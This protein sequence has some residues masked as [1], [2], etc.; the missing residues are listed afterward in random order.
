MQLLIWAGKPEGEN[1]VIP[2]EAQEHDR[3]IEEIAMSVLQDE[4][5]TG[6]AA[7][8][9]ICRLTHRARR[10]VQEER[11]VKSF[12]IVVAGGAEAQ[13]KSQNQH[14]R[15]K[16]QR[17][18]VVVRVDQGRV[19]GRE[20]RTPV[21][22]FSLEGAER[23]INTEPSHHDDNRKIFQPPG[24]APQCA[25]QALRHNRASALSQNFTSKGEL[26]TD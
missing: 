7:I 8:V 1:S 25:A 18:P 10:R 24:I 22:K 5:E 9:A 6:F 19:K 4:R 14:G 26:K 23:S 3:A 21:V 17:Q 12:A 20:V 2:E 13:R 16:P 11:A 15:R